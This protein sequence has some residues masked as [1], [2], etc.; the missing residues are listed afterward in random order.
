MSKTE[1][2]VELIA[3]VRKTFHSLTHAG[4]Q[5]IQAGINMGQRGVLEELH[6]NGKQTIPE[7]ARTKGVSRQ[8][9]LKLVTP[10]E[11]LDFVSFE[12]N[13]AHKRSFIVALT[14]KG[15]KVITD[16]LAS[17]YS[18]LTKL[19]KVLKQQDLEN[20]REVLQSF[21][22]LLDGEFR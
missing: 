1:S 16:T 15:E 5:L 8:H 13:P 22:D 18:A 7:I 12:E 6:G 4:E 17:E 21:R 11:K 10:L 14:G 2:I 9:I 19:G 3:E 20:A